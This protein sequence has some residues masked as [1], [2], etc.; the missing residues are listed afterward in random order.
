[1][2]VVIR[3]SDVRNVAKFAERISGGKVKAADHWH[4]NERGIVYMDG[5]SHLSWNG[6]GAS[7]KAFA[8]YFGGCMP[9]INADNRAEWR[10]FN[11]I[12]ETIEN[13]PGVNK[14]FHDGNAYGLYRKG[15]KL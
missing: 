1:M 13:R 2:T 8:Y 3:E 6:K 11:A 9:F 4:S 7:S 10:T 14:A 15:G 5:N 12:Y